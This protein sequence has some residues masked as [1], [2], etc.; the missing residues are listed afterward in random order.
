MVRSAAAA[1][2]WL[3]GGGERRRSWL[4]R[5]P[6]VLA[7]LLAL[8]ACGGAPPQ[9]QVQV[10]DA[11]AQ[12]RVIPGGREPQ[13]GPNCLLDAQCALV[14]ETCP[15]RCRLNTDPVGLAFPNMVC[16]A[17]LYCSPC[18]GRVAFCDLRTF[19]CQMR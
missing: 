11:G 4:W 18:G 8:V 14:T 16:V 2:S 12:V 9:A 1:G 3:T 17:A 13:H 10:E 19:T 6:E 5:R 15:C 7:G